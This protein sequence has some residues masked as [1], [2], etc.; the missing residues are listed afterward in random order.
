MKLGGAGLG[1]ILL[2][3]AAW[4]CVAQSQENGTA[5]SSS[6]AASGA[7][8]N[9]PTMQGQAENAPVIDS[10]AKKTDTTPGSPVATPNTSSDPKKPK[11]VWTNDDMRSMHGAVSVVGDAK[12]PNRQDYED[13]VEEEDNGQQAQIQSYR[14]QIEQI[15]G[16]IQA[17]DDRMAQLKNFK[18]E[19][20]APSG[21]INLK[22]EYNMVPVEEQ[23]KQ[24]EEKRKK[25][26][27][28]IGQVEDAAR[29]SGIDPG[30][31]R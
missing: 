6:N 10:T 11:K 21:G 12:R 14:E 20:G 19:N 8:T 2:L 27:E 28:Q 3:A 25:L 1:A 29:K 23:V 30:E 16:Q 22:Q 31:L 17:I 7:S 18:A 13:D 5:A 4:P 26:E 15:R 24:L 9:K